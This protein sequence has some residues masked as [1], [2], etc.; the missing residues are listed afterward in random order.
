MMAFILAVILVLA[1][2]V[3]LYIAGDPPARA[4]R[5]TRDL[6]AAQTPYLAAAQ[7]PPAVD[8]PVIAATPEEAARCEIEGLLARR[9]ITGEIDRDAYH[10]A[11]A[12]LAVRDAGSRPLH[13][14]GD[15]TG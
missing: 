3:V 2:F 10:D 1:P 14:P 9:L 7:V 6:A 12:E 5:R 8:L 15:S 11:M 13:V 4:S